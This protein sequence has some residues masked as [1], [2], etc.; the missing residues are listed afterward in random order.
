ML[1]LAVAAYPLLAILTRGESRQAE[2]FG[3]A[4]D[5]TVLGTLGVLCTARGR[6][7]ALLAIIPLLWAVAS[8]VTLSLLGAPEAWVLGGSTLAV[9][10]ALAPARTRAPVVVP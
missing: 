4:P 9:L 3:I 7:R 8:A 2:V 6:G 5:P 1:V 10:I